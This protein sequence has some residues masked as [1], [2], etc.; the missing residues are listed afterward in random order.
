M[1]T[2]EHVS[3]LHVGE[4]SGY[5]P[6]NGI[7]G[8][9]GSTTSNFL[10]NC[11]TDF[12]SCCTSLQS[13]QQWKSVPLS[14]HPLQHL[15]SPEFFIFWLMWG[16]TSGF[17]FICISLLIKDVEHFFRCFSAIQY[18]SVE[19]SLFSSEPY[20]LMGLKFHFLIVFVWGCG[21]WEGRSHAQHQDLN[22]FSVQGHWKT[23][24]LI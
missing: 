7:A 2:V 18:S 8:S 5:R 16:R 1:N 21:G 17:F 13:R 15:Q 22:H 24:T 20:F 4:S 3:L 12:Q 9:F 14:T 6:R 10:R 19:N 23:M 11:Q